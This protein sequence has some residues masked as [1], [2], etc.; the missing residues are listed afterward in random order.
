MRKILEF[1][2]LRQVAD[3]DCGACALQCV[4]VYYGR[5][6][7]EDAIAMAAGT[8]PAEGTSIAGMLSVLQHF[9]LKYFAGTM[10]LD[11]VLAAI[12]CGWP[13]IVA[14]QAYSNSPRRYQD[15]NEDGH[16]VVAIGYDEEEGRC[17]KILFED[18]SA[19]TRTWLTPAELAA[20]WHDVDGGRPLLHWGC[21]VKGAAQF[22]A[23]EAVHML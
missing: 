1:P 9:A 4:L 16:Y 22:H 3:F 6:E 8:N 19:Y 7:R 15:D 23:G 13:V 14:L 11:D 5:P 20:R 2:E 17:Q 10:Q 12:D 21:I 18:P